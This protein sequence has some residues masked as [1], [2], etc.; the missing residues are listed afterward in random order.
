MNLDLAGYHLTYDQEF[1]RPRDFIASPTGMLGFKTQYDWGGRTVP[2]NSEAEFYS[3]PSF[4][5]NPF[6]VENGEL[7]ITAS[8]ATA[9]E[10][11]GGMPYISGM[12]TTQNTFSQHGGY[13]EMRA[14]AAGGQGLWP[15]FWLL[16]TNLQDY[17]E[18]DI[19]EDPNLGPG[20]MYWLHASGSTGGG[21]G[22]F[23]PGP[24]LAAG[25]HA[26]G[27]A[28]TDN[29]CTFYFDGQAVGEYQTPANFAAINMYMIINLAVGGIDSWPSTPGPNS[30]PAEYRIDYIRVFSNNSAIPAVPPGRM[31]SP[32]G[33]NTFP[34]MH[35]AALP[36]ISTGFGPDALVLKASEQ[37]FDG[38]AQFTVSIDGVQQGGIFSSVVENLRHHSQEF[39]F[40]GSYTP[41]VHTVAVTFSNDAYGGTK[42]LDR[43]LYVTGGT[44]DGAAIPGSALNL[45]NNGTQSFT[46]TVPTP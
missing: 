4:G 10:M 17:P 37:W 16:P 43:N 13:F 19:M 31:S 23:S 6:K 27:V 39:V 1:T 38:D 3:D 7:T 14:M 2:S 36:P 29:T 9:N 11:S 22:F 34:P 25:Y 12:I 18:M 28:W 32:D 21:G 15:A 33:A 42:Y 24:T 46:F 5:D 40:N 20:N 45:L 26:Y 35:P 30:I 44:I 8:A 41:G